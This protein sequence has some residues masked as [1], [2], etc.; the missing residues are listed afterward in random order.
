MAR[1]DMQELDKS[2][3]IAIRNKIVE[4]LQNPLPKGQGGR[5]IPLGNKAGNNLTNCLEVKHRGIGLRAVYMLFKKENDMYVFIISSREDSK[6]YDLAMK[7]L[8]QVQTEYETKKAEEQLNT[9]PNSSP[10]PEQDL[11][12][13]FDL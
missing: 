10:A 1:K 6:V 9:K 7:R 3:R 5:G 8:S 11:D 4:V 13:D 2:Q 12:D